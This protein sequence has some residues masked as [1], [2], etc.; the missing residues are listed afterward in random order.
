MKLVKLIL[1][2]IPYVC[3]LCAQKPEL[4]SIHHAFRMINEDVHKDSI[5]REIRFQDGKDDTVSVV[6]F[7]IVDSPKYPLIVS[8]KQTTQTDQLGHLSFTL[9][10]EFFENFLWLIDNYTQKKHTRKFDGVLLRVTYRYHGKISQYYVTNRIFASSYLLM[11]DEEL[12]PSTDPK[13]LK[14]FHKFVY[15][16]GLIK[17]VRGK[18]VWTELQ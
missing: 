18:V 6:R 10:G 13:V 11:I 9:E 8:I 15:D 7:D 4:K 2:L 3:S 12:R 17:F 16:A 14:T 1:I 5:I